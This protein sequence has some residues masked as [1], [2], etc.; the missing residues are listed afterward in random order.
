MKSRTDLGISL[1]IK[2]VY[3]LVK[4]GIETNSKL[5]KPKTYNKI[6]DYPIY[7]NK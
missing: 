5:R 3:K 7:K 4:S 1:G 2:P 6:I